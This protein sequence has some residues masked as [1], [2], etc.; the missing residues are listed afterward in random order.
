MNEKNVHQMHISFSM[1]IITFLYSHFFFYFSVLFVIFNFYFWLYYTDSINHRKWNGFECFCCAWV[2]IDIHTTPFRTIH[3]QFLFLF[4]CLL[5]FLSLF[6]Y[7]FQIYKWG[8]KRQQFENRMSFF[9]NFENYVWLW[10]VKK[11]NDKINSSFYSLKDYLYT[12]FKKKNH[13]L[14]SI[15]SKDS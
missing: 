8:Q 15:S 5:F 12:R 4:F 14:P 7:N 13:F 6:F 11:T 1:H 2:Q 3:T 9:F 10:N